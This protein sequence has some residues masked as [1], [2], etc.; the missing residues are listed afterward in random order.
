MVLCFMIGSIPESVGDLVNLTQL[1]I[2][3]AGITG[4]PP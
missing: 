3:Y 4:T 1:H 2:S